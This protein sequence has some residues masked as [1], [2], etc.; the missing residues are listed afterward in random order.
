MRTPKANP[1]VSYTRTGGVVLLLSTCVRLRLV[2]SFVVV[3]S[4]LFYLSAFLVIV[5]YFFTCLF[6]SAYFPA[7]HYVLESWYRGDEISRRGGVFYVG[8]TTGKL[9]ADLLQSAATTHLDG[10]HGL[11]G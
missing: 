9:T 7:D 4:L 10:L 2:A 5:T 1:R 6:E 8:L 11:A 3:F